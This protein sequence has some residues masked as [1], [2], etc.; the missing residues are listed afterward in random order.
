MIKTILDFIRI[1]QWYKNIIIFIPL[2]FSFEFFVVEK[3]F[4]TIIGFIAI[5]F[6][7]S[8]CYVRNDIKDFEQDKLDP[9]KKKRDLHSGLI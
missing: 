9:S 1:K 5:S 8:A 2:V 6:V 4:I 7:S 3:L